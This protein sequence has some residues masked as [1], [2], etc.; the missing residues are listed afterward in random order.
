MKKLLSLMGAML[1]LSAVAQNCCPQPPDG[2]D[3]YAEAPAQLPGSS[4]IAT[5]YY[6]GETDMMVGQTH[7][8]QYLAFYHP[9]VTGYTYEVQYTDELLGPWKA[10]ARWIAQKDDI[11]TTF[12][13]IYPC[14]PH[15]FIRVCA[16]PPPVL[17]AFITQHHSDN[18]NSPKRSH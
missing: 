6:T 3:C 18:G 15:R 4:Q 12:V 2:F 9:E 1:T 11:V 14:V 16:T 7:V 13:P 5:A 10:Y 8:T 17:S